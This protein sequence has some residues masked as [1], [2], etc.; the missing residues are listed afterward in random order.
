MTANWNMASSAVMCRILYRTICTVAMA[1]HGVSKDKNKENYSIY[2]DVIGFNHVISHSNI[3]TLFLRQGFG[4]KSKT[5]RTNY[6]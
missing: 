5:D 3:V 6:I 4:F 2:S 1:M